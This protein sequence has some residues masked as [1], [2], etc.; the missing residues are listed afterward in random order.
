MNK[1]DKIGALYAAAMTVYFLVSGLSVLFDVPMKLARISLKAVNADGE[2]AFI[3][4]YCGLMV[5][6]GVANIIFWR[7]S[8]T[9]LYPAVLSTVI[10]ASFILFRL[11]GSYMVGTISET[12]AGFLVV[13]LLE[14]GLGCLIIWRCG[15]IKRRSS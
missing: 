11:V 1:S 3:L 5:G 9:W 13:E 15:L 6:I 7:F 8:K 10:V 12:Q 14:L 2:I 4:I